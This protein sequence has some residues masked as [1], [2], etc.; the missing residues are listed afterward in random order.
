MELECLGSMTMVATV[1]IVCDAVSRVVAGMGRAVRS[2]SG[3]RCP[4]PPQ[5]CIAVCSLLLVSGS[6][7]VPQTRAA[8][9]VGGGVDVYVAV[10]GSDV[11]CV[12]GDVLRPCA[13]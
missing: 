5:L 12:R 9:P 3:L 6:T 11:T 8:G 13:S 7:A 4:L 2:A 1:P 10:A